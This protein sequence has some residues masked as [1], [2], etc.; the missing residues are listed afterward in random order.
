MPLP[1]KVDP[2]YQERLDATKPSP[3]ELFAGDILALVAENKRLR[4]ETRDL[5]VMIYRASRNGSLPMA[6][7]PAPENITISFTGDNVWASDPNAPTPT[8]PAVDS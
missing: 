1:I 3:L 8:A 6:R 2:T 5:Q 4:R 7:V